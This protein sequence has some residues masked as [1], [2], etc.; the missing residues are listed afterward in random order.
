[1]P[2]FTLK[3]VRL[4]A[5]HLPEVRRDDIVR[6]LSGIHRPEID[7]A[8]VEPR[9]RIRT[10]DVRAIPWRQW[11]MS[12][13]DAGKLIAAAVT[14][15]RMVRPAPKRSRWSPFRRTR[16]ETFSR[17]RDNLV[18][19]VRPA[20]RRSRRRLVAVVI[21]LS[22]VASWLMIRNPGVRAR[23]DGIGADARRRISEIRS[24]NLADKELETATPVP[25]MSADA[26]PTG[27][28]GDIDAVVQA[29][30]TDGA[31]NPA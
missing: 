21:A 1:M 4:P 24:R 25:V 14:A 6:A 8:T 9:R 18:A 15:A 17:S 7:A 10:I 2:E 19:V 30:V 3:E 26:V 28:S 11:G 16:W 31:A 29:G 12:G 22:A 5:F 23:L 27:A 20:R 13:T